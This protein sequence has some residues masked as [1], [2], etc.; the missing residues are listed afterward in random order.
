MFDSWQAAKNFNACVD[1]AYSI[2]P[3]V[4]G[5]SAVV[6]QLKYQDC[7]DSF[8]QITG[9]Q[10]PGGENYLTSR[11]Q[12]AAFLGPVSNFFIWAIVFLFALFL[13]NSA[14]IVVPVETIEIPLERAVVP[15]KKK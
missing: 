3:D 15:K 6:T 2:E 12:L 10:I 11:Q 7:K 4:S 13:I 5:I 9:A 14:T 8:Y 1:D